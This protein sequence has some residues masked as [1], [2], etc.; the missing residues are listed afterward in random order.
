MSKHITERSESPTKAP[1]QY[2]GTGLSI[3][4][5]NSVYYEDSDTWGHGLRGT[6]APEQ[7][8]QPVDT[9]QYRAPDQTCCEACRESKDDT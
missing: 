5:T 4:I 2:V 3:P 9:K 1:G 6:N 8:R 7:E